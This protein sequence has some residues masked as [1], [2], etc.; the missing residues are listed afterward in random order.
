MKSLM[1]ARSVARP[2]NGDVPFDVDL[3]SARAREWMGTS[4][5]GGV[6]GGVMS[7]K[8]DRVVDGVLAPRLEVEKCLRGAVS[9]QKIRRLSTTLKRAQSTHFEHSWGR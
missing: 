2:D 3:R 6:G 1:S 4:T 5:D 8:C 7:V 9:K